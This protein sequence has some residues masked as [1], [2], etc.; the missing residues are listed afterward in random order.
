MALSFT[1]L[2]CVSTLL[3]GCTPEPNGPPVKGEESSEER[4]YSK[5]SKD[6]PASR[7]PKN[8]CSQS[9]DGLR[10]P[11]WTDSSSVNVNISPVFAGSPNMDEVSYDDTRSDGWDN[12]SHEFDPNRLI[13]VALK[14][15][16][17]PLKADDLTRFAFQPIHRDGAH[18]VCEDAL[19]TTVRFIGNRDAGNNQEASVWE[20]TSDEEFYRE[21]EFGK[22][23][24]TI[25]QARIEGMPDRYVKRQQK[26]ESGD[27]GTP[28]RAPAFDDLKFYY[29]NR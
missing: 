9:G 15:S 3:A 16:S 12:Y 5:S 20:I 18:T 17:L 11:V 2:A 29:Q 19:D 6:T 4:T 21:P 23:S 7:T 1:A 28:K 10:E 8:A 27:P 22:V 13:L 25:R 26:V 24:L 14:S